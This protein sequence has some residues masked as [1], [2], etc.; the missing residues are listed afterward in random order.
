MDLHSGR[1][2]SFA[3]RPSQAKDFK[4]GFASFARFFPDGKT[5]TAQIEEAL[6]GEL[7]GLGPKPSPLIFDDQYISTGGQLYEVL[8]GHDRMIADI[9]PMVFAKLGIQ[10]SL[11]C[12]PYDICTELIL[13]EAGGIVESPMGRRL[14]QKLDT[15]TP[16]AWISYANETLANQVRPILRRLLKKFL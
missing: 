3:A 9:R 1:S 16:V 8:V 14:N 12:H 5:L 13:R 11:T 7:Y 10:S 4:H 6:W 2:K 15:T